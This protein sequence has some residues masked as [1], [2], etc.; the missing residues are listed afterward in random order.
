[1]KRIHFER[2][3]AV[4]LTASTFAFA[5]AGPA[6]ADEIRESQWHLTFM[7]TDQAHRYS[8]GDNVIVAVVDSGV[9]ASHPDLGGAVLPG[10]DTDGTGDGR[11]D[12]DGHGTAVAGLIAARGRNGDAGV[13]GIAPK[14]TVVPIAAGGP[15]NPAADEAI[16]LAVRHRATVVCLAFGSSGGSRLE[17]AVADAVYADAVVV[18]AAG[19]RP[20]VSRVQAPARYPGVLAVAGVDSSGRHADISVAGPE[21]ALS[22]PAVGIVSTGLHGGY[23]KSDGTSDAAAIVAGAVALVR[24]KYPD[25]KAPEVIHRLTATAIDKGK[26]GRDDEYGYGVIDLV[27]ALTADVPPLGSSAP[28]A[29]TPTSAA[30]PSPRDEPDRLPVGWIVAGVLLAAGGVGAALALRR[31]MRG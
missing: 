14:S 7:R 22:A 6:W 9:D 31:R 1:V 5:F 25:L 12:S 8:A 2:L 4:S 28:S 26:P 18:A 29:A 17:R 23:I 27:A 13:L 19:N 20:A 10:S 11:Q 3:L 15:G 30:A 21:I 24:A 16:D